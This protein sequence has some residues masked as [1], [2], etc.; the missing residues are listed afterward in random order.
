MK[1]DL[2]VTGPVSI[3]TFDFTLEDEWESMMS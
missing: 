2:A 3:V 1:V